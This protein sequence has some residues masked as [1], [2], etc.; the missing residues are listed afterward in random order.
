MTGEGLDSCL[1]IIMEYQQIVTESG[2]F[3]RKRSA[4]NSLW[5]WRFIN[6]HLQDLFQRDPRV[7]GIAQGITDAVANELITPLAGAK[8]LLLVFL[9]QHTTA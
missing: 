7:S 9:N 5:M 2:E 1:K 4:Q 6:D 3:L 8:Y